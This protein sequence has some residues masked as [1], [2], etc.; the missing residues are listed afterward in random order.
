MAKKPKNEIKLVKCEQYTEFDNRFFG[1]YKEQSEAIEQWLTDHIKEK[2]GDKKEYHGA[3][4]GA[5]T[6]EF[7]PTS[8]GIVTVF[9]CYCGDGVN[10]SDY[11]EW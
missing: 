6:Y 7:T 5:Y 9:K 10:V 11:S 1:L 4:G 3:I 8:L 2:H